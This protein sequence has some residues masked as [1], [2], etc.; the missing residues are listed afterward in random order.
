M[1]KHIL[2]KRHFLRKCKKPG[3]LFPMKGCRQ[4]LILKD[5][6]EV[7]L[8]KSAFIRGRFVDDDNKRLRFNKK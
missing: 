5:Y 4:C 7:N 2:K 6:R 1:V 8:F 3:K